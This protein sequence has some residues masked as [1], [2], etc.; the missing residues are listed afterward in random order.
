MSNPSDNPL[1]KIQQASAEGRYADIAELIPEEARGNVFQQL[2]FPTVISMMDFKNYK[3]LNKT[4]LADI[5]KW[6]DEDQQGVLRS[7]ANGWHSTVD[8]HTRDEFKSM[9][10][11]FLHQAAEVAKRLGFDEDAEPIICNMWANVSPYGAFNKN[12]NHPNTILSLAYYV[13]APPGCGRFRVTDPRP[14]TKVMMPPFSKTKT[15]PTEMFEEVYYEPIPGRCIMFPSWLMHEVEPNLTE[16]QG[17]DGMRISVSANIFF[18][19]KSNTLKVKSGLNNK[20]ILTID[21]EVLEPTGLVN[22]LTD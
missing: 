2:W 6:R 21:G 20:G 11:Q 4:W 8:M 19:M 18:R 5:L 15:R 17:D 9:G 16:V 1:E 14:Q 3:E 13:Q 22:M 7:N 12:H 10:L